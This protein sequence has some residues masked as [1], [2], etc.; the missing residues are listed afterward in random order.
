MLINILKMTMTFVYLKI[1]LIGVYFTRHFARASE[2]IALRRPA[3]QSSTMSSYTADR[4]VDGNTG[5][6]FFEDNSCSHTAHGKNEAWWQVNLLQLSNIK[7]V[8][9][10]YRRNYT[11]RFWGFHLFVSNTSDWSSGYLCYNHKGPDLPDEIQNVSCPT[12]DCD[13]GS[14]GSGCRGRCYCMQGT[15]DPVSGICPTGG[16]Q[17]GWNGKSCN[18]ACASFTY[19]PDCKFT[20]HCKNSTC[21]RFTGKCLYGCEEGWVGPNCNQECMKISNDHPRKAVITCLIIVAVS[22]LVINILSCAI[23]YRKKMSDC[24][25]GRVSYNVHVSNPAYDINEKSEDITGIHG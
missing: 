21:D 11:E 18:K 17:G 23:Y 8:S 20:C 25:G 19:G 4:A 22:L 2:N 16:C 24:R 14:F 9:I 15:C 3:S 13:Y 1:V 10:F 7:K 12:I 5:N 6:L